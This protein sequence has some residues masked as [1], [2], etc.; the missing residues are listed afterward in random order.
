[1]TNIGYGRCGASMV[2]SSFVEVEHNHTHML[3]GAGIFTY[4][5]WLVFR[6]NVGIHIPAPWSI[7]G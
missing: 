6:A 1:M 2:P 4:K 5:T 3:H 7:Y